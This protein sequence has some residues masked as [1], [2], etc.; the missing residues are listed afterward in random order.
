MSEFI[1]TLAKDAVAA[2]RAELPEATD[3]A[4]GEAQFERLELLIGET[5]GAAL[6]H[7]AEQIEDLARL[8]RGQ[9]ESPAADIEL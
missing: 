8:L 9:G 1:E 3:Q 7:A 2:F 6:R 4:I 5:T